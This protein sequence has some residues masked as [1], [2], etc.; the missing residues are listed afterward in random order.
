MKLA[1]IIALDCISGNIKSKNIPGEDA[2]R[3]PP[4]PPPPPSQ[5]P[6]IL[7]VCHFAFPTIY[8]LTTTVRLMSCED[9]YVKSKGLRATG[10]DGIFIQ[11]TQNGR[12]QPRMLCAVA[13]AIATGCKALPPK[14]HGERF[15][16]SN[17]LPV[18]S[19]VCFSCTGKPFPWSYI[20]GA[21]ES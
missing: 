10:E 17:S 7:V 8:Y 20:H 4:P 6:K 1:H 12:E 14:S 19:P 5:K 15:A 3:P 13:I 2:P 21:T 18:S 11:P 9:G 16:V